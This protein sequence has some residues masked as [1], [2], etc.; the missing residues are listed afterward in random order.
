MPWWWGR[1]G[2]ACSHG[3]IKRVGRRSYPTLV[4]QQMRSNFATGRLQ[5]LPYP[6]RRNCRPKPVRRLG[7]HG[8]WRWRSPASECRG[9]RGRRGFAVE[10][11]C[12][13]RAV[14]VHRQP[15]QGHLSWER[16]RRRLCPIG[17]CDQVAISWE[18]PQSAEV[19]GQTIGKATVEDTG[20]HGG[21][22]GAQVW[23]ENRSHPPPWSGDWLY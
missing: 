8:S 3:A 20:R 1:A 23:G 15:R 4:V 9:L 16:P 7:S 18:P 11:G 6:G 12:V 19:F 22:H 10:L 5:R 21:D 17:I 2:S 13:D 14:I